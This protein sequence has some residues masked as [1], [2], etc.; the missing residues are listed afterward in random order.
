[1]AK[2]EKIHEKLLKT[3]LSNQRTRNLISKIILKEFLHT[4]QE[5]RAFELLMV[6]HHFNL[7]ILDEMLPNIST[8]KL[9]Q[10]FIQ[11]QNS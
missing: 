3:Q 10:L 7:D 11:N 9:S 4:V 2:I 6:A 1:M 5:T 8:Q